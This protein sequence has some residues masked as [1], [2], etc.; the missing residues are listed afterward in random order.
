MERGGESQRGDTRTHTTSTR[1]CTYIAKDTLCPLG[2]LQAIIL[3]NYAPV[4]GEHEPQR[5][6]SNGRGVC[7]CAVCDPNAVASEKILKSQ[8]PSIFNI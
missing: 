2:L 3:R 6:L 7:A 8:C 4:A 1:T 5:E